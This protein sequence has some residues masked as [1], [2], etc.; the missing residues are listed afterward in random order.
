MADRE[1]GRLFCWQRQM[2]GACRKCS[3]LTEF[4]YRICAELTEFDS[5]FPNLLT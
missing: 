3:E 5:S 1:T 2:C 4:A